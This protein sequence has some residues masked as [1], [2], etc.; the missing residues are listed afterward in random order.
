MVSSD[1]KPRVLIAAKER[2]ARER[3]RQS[4]LAG[5]KYQIAGTASDGQ[6][7]VQMAVLL[8]PDVALIEYDLPIIDG[9]RTAEM[10]G[11]AAPEVRSVLLGNG[12]PTPELLRKAM[13]AGVRA[14]L[15]APV[16]SSDVVSVI[17][18][19]SAADDMRSTPEYQA[20]TDPN[21]LPKTIAITGAK[22]GI[23]KTTI[24][25]S[26]AMYLGLRYPGKVVLLDMYTQF[27]DVAT[28]LDIK[29]QRSLSDLAYSAGE[30][31]NDV[32]DTCMVEHETGIKVL[33]CSTTTQPIDSIGT[34]E[35]E[36]VIHLL[37]RNYL[38]TIIDIPPILHATSLYL[39][40]HCS[41]VLLITTL[42]DMPTVS[43]CMHLY[44]KLTSSYTPEEKI[45]LIANRVSKHDRLSLRDVE[46]LFGRSIS[47]L[48]PN[49]PRLVNVV[50]QGVP[51]VQAYPRSPLSLAVGKIADEIVSGNVGVG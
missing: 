40:A 10:V 20:A 37:K 31:D 47:V 14:Y 9:F 51:F 36:S 15:P 21:R 6:E 2:E 44:E 11:L 1:H 5:G 24:A 3:L 32:L 19:L 35:I 49:D 4:V 26:L 8:R 22:G 17:N 23:G 12:Q 50:N 13:S 48:V 41:R 43:N 18:S 45:M 29:P 27:G 38:Y 46:K 42:F 28:M 7:A 39:A 16:D 33:V 25:T 30:M 34:N